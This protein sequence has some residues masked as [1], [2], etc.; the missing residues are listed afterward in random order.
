MAITARSIELVLFILFLN[1]I[2]FHEK[3]PE[4]IGLRGNGATNYR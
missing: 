4:A 2:S 3:L 1:N